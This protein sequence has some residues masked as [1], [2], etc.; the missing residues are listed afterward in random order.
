MSHIHIVLHD[1][2]THTHTHAETG[3]SPTEN[4]DEPCKEGASVNGEKREGTEGEA[5]LLTL[6]RM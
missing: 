5:L 4:E 2:D 6:R 1:S 3:H